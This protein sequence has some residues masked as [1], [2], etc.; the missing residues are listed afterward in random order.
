MLHPVL[1]SNE[2]SRNIVARH[3][4]TDALACATVSYYGISAKKWLRQFL[5][6]HDPASYKKRLWGYVPEAQRI[7]TVFLAYQIK[8]RRREVT[9][10]NAL[11]LRR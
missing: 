1:A 10:C 4:G 8:V 6:P 2:V 9:S 5:S 3:L 7:L 11:V